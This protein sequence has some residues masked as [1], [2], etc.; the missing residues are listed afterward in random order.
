MIVVRLQLPARYLHEFTVEGAGPFPVDMLRYDS[1][2]PR[3]ESTAR[4]LV[5]YEAP[6]RQVTLHRFSVDR[7]WG[8]N[9][10]RW[11]SFGWR[12]IG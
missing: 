10:E 4:S 8:P 7:D 2:H 5:D 9:R 11:A 1:C 3:D 12:V 6:R